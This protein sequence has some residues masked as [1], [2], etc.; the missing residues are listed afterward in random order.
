LQL[1]FYNSAGVPVKVFISW[2]GEA[3]RQ[4]A[5]ALRDWLPDVIQAIKPWTSI[6]DI[7]KGERWFSSI[8]DALQD[9]K[10][11]GIFCVTPSNVASP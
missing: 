2:S 10:G 8:S 5:S 7:D 11:Y 1:N 4:V 9:A 6:E 3:S